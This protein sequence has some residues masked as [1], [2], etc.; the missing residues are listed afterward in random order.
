[1]HGARAAQNHVSPISVASSER[2]PGRYAGYQRLYNAALEQR[3]A[4]WRLQ[5]KRI[6]E[7][8][9]SRDLTE[10][11]AA[12]PEYRALNAQ[13]AQVTLHRLN[14][15]YEAF[16]RRYKRG[17]APGFPRFR[18]LERFSGWGYKQCGDGFQFTPGDGNR[19]GRLRLSGIGTL[20]VRGRGRT[21]GEI[22]TC[23][24]QHK[25]G[26]WYATLT[27]VCKPRRIGGTAA[28]GLDWG[29]ETFATIA[30]DDRTFS[31]IPNPRF[32]RQIKIGLEQA[33]QDLA[34]KARRSKN[35]AKSRA[36]LAALYRKNA[37]R[38][39]DFLHKESASVVAQAALVATESLNVVNMTRSTRGTIKSPGRNVAQKSG[40]NREIL[41]TAP[42]AFLAMLRY[43]AEEAGVE[44]V[45]LPSREVK[46]S[47]TCSGCGLQRKKALSERQHMCACG[48]NLTR[49]QN[50]ARVILLWARARS[51]PGTDSR[52]PRESRLASN[53]KLPPRV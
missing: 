27:I 48:V 16:F 52:V 19:H 26:R 53:T 12:D 42:S 5:R 39:R 28:I 31:T 9:Q 37:N 21:P 51:R 47:Q 36:V 2:S 13:S 18:S 43:K 23:D 8:D 7:Y 44:F 35:R 45:E 46:P 20:Q 11:R 29:V 4:A 14:C 32:Y 17:E 49:D 25:G 15:A 1:M 40:L 22:K 30:H 6:S 38:R 33:Q 41:A 3:K 24:I 50:A 10:L 34:R